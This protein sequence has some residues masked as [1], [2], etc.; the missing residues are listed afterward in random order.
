MSLWSVED[1][2]TRNWMKALYEARLEQGLDTAESVRE[3]S[4][5]VLEERRANGESTHPF[6]WGA[7]VAA[8]DWR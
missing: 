7:F 1:Q 8:G 6:Y 2:A 4:L 5:Q 3:A